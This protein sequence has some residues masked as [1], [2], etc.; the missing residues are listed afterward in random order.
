MISVESAKAIL[1]QSVL[2]ITATERMKVAQAL[3]HALAEDV[4]ASISL[5]PFNQSNVDGYAVCIDSETP[6]VWTVVGE[7]KAGDAANVEL[8][9]GEAVRIF[10]GAMVPETADLVIMQEHCTRVKNRVEYS[11]VSLKKGEHIRYKG[12]QIKQGEL[13]LKSGVFINPMTIGFLSGLGLETITV[14]KQ[15]QIALLITGNEL[16]APGSNLIGGKVFDSNSAALQSAIQLMG[17]KVE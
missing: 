12:A 14:Y 13:A 2:P 15:P 9:K 11:L 1:Q 8:K 3:G 7:I 17:L 10:T 6:N 16:Q 5:P 4:L